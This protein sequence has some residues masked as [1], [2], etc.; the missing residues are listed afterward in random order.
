MIRM[1]DE[2]I[3][4][5]KR[6]NPGLCHGLGIH[7][8]DGE[9]S[10]LSPPSITKRIQEIE[11]DLKSLS[12]IPEPTN[13]TEKY[14]YNLIISALNIELYELRDRKEYLE[15]PLPYIFGFFSPLTSIEN[16]YTMRSFAPLDER[17]K[18]IIKLESNFPK[19]LQQA[20]GNLKDATFS[21]AACSFALDMM[22]GLIS[23]YT[24]ELISFVSKTEDT[25]LLDQWSKSNEDAVDALKSFN[26]FL[27]KKMETASDNFALGKETFL[28]MLE[29]TEGV[30]STVEDLLRIGERDL[31][32]NYKELHSIADKTHNGDVQAL[33]DE[34]FSDF[35]KPEDLISY[36]EETLERTKNFLVQNSIVSIP[37]DQQC[38]VIH[39]P[40]SAR[41]F[42]FA[43]MN[44]PGPFE[45]PEASE[46]YYW[47]T[48]PDPNWDTEKTTG[49]MKL[50]NKASMESITIHEVWPGHY[51]Q[52]LF[53]NKT[54]STIA[55]LYA[56]SYAMIEGWAHY[57]EE[58]IYD[59]GYEPFDRSKYKIGQLLEALI[60]NVRFVC[61]IN[62]HCN[63]MTL[64]EATKLFV[65]KGFL[66]EENAYIEAR[67]GTVDP[68]YLNYTL[69]KLMIMQLREEYK[70]E[71]GESYSL[72]KFHDTL[73]SF[74]SPPITVLRKM[75]LKN[76]SDKIVG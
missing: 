60:R 74:G 69:G 30:K 47:V 17:I 15:S 9:I 10:D 12:A 54:E 31:E 44:T 1:F 49:F 8:F 75:M 4:R 42:A 19:Y 51:L 39:T 70:A 25:Q 67:R 21:K 32:R 38:K 53:S 2:I 24:D 16:S 20:Q 13:Q 3:E 52:L 73:L 62:L 22:S 55:K 27:N 57:T 65:D 63:G 34:T 6:F 7:D 56:Y 26:Q 72:K 40:K 29:K 61:A 71:L 11:S 35:P 76:P 5:W 58:M 23:Y 59:E 45:V 14:E 68:M 37:S 33:L 36:A 43:A 66:S 18:S 64:E 46:A 50:F 41:K 48:P 28:E